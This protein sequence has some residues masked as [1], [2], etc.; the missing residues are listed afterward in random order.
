M[1]RRGHLLGGL[2]YKA[3]NIPFCMIKLLITLGCFNTRSHYKDGRPDL[4]AGGT[5]ISPRGQW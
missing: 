1:P 2:K 3:D 4:A 5:A